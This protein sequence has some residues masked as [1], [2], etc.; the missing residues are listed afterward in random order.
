VQV[1]YCRTLM[2]ELD[3]ATQHSTSVERWVTD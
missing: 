1:Y 3:L 2:R